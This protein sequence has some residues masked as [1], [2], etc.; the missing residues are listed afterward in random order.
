MKRFAIK[1]AVITL[2][3]VF[4]ALMLLFIGVTVCSPRTM[5]NLFYDVGNGTLSSWY[6]ELSYQKTGSTEDLKKLILRADEVEDYERLEK[7]CEVLTEREDFSSIC[8][9]EKEGYKNYVFGKYVIAMYKNDKT[10]DE[11]FIVADKT[12][13]GGY[14][15][16]NAYRSLLYGAG[17]AGDLDFIRSLNDKFSDMDCTDELFIEDKTFLQNLT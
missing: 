14:V 6:T 9:A 3:S 15:D 10:A 16:D 17:I 11:I 7:Y 4:A 2:I 12:L 13:D 5:A 1:T 8:D